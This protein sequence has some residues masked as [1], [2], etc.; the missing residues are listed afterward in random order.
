MVWVWL[1]GL[2]LEFWLEDVF[3]GNANS[4]GELVAIDAMIVAQ[5]RLACPSNPKN[6]QKHNNHVKQIWKEKIN[7][8]EEGRAEGGSGL[9]SNPKDITNGDRKASTSKDTLQKEVRKD[10]DNVFEVKIVN[11]FEVLQIQEEE[12][13][14]I[15]EIL[16]EGEIGDINE[17]QHEGKE[18]E[19]EAENEEEKEVEGEEG[20]EQRKEDV[21]EIEVK[22]NPYISDRRNDVQHNME[23]GNPRSMDSA[24][25]MENV[26]SILNVAKNSTLEMFNFQKWVIDNISSIQNNRRDLDYKIENLIKDANTK[27][28]EDV[29]KDTSDAEDE[30]EISN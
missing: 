20:D 23:E 18:V 19:E 13:V 25:I 9:P 10:E 5:K 17:S 1:P 2:P 21:E 7:K 8:N 11:G 26:D 4:F 29:A 22:D 24:S 3:S 30:E 27:G 15:E 6:A 28:K 12:N 16:E 14:S